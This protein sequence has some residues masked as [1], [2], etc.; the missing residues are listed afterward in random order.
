[1]SSNH[2]KQSALDFVERGP[3]HEEE[4]AMGT[5]ESKQVVKEVY[6]AFGRETQWPF[7]S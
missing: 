5:Q 4:I 6:A 7:S 3:S 1:M 2:E